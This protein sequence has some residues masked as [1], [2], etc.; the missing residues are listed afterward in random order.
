MPPLPLRPRLADHA[1]ARGHVVGGELRVVLHDMR[2]GGLIDVGPREWV[3]LAA[4]D[5]TRDVD[6]LALAARNEGARVGVE[7]VRA[8]AATEITVVADAVGAG[9]D[10]LPPQVLD[11]GLRQLA[12]R[13]PSSELPATTLEKYAPSM[14]GKLQCLVA[15][16]RRRPVPEIVT[17]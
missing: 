17:A 15:A 2:G 11:E 7:A 8:L 4:A 13:P 14:T 9:W 16:A 1:V 3:L 10:R 5:G 12:T 6:G